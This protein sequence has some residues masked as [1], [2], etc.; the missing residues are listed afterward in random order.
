MPSIQSRLP[1]QK[2]LG[3]RIPHIVR[4][5]IKLFNVLAVDVFESRFEDGLVRLQARSKGKGLKTWSHISPWILDSKSM[6]MSQGLRKVWRCR[7]CATI[8]KSL[9]VGLGFFYRL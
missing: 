8:V 3:P 5:D 6:T 2:G 9:V 7:S 1:S 4:G